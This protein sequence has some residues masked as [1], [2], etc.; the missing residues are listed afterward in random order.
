MTSIIKIYGHHKS[1]NHIQRPQSSTIQKAAFPIFEVCSLFLS[2]CFVLCSRFFLYSIEYGDKQGTED[3]GT[4]GTEQDGYLA[5][6]TEHVGGVR[7]EIAK[8]EGV[9]EDGHGE[10]NAS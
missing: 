3:A 5:R 6:G 4:E 2:L 9:N 10:A 8:R 7:A 1:L